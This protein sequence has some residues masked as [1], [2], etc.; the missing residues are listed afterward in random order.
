MVTP[1]VFNISWFHHTNS[2][3]R[4]VLGCPFV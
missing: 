2:L 1:T 4:H 3:R